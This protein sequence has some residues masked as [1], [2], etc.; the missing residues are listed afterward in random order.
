MLDQAAAT[1]DLPGI[2]EPPIDSQLFR[3]VFAAANVGK[4][5]T[6]ADGRVFP[7]QTFADMLGYSCEELRG[8]DWRSLTPPEDLPAIEAD[9]QRL[10]RDET[11][12]LRLLK[13]YVRKDRTIMWGDVSSVARRDPD[14]RL[15]YFITTIID[16]TDR[17]ATEARLRRSQERFTQAFQLGPAGMSIT[18]IS[19]GT[20]L[21]VNQEF[22]RTFGF[23]RAEVIGRTSVE[24]QLYSPEARAQLIRNQLA[25]GG[26]RCTLLQ[27]RAKTGESRTIRFSSQPVTIEDEP[28]HVTMFVDETEL[29]EIRDRERQAVQGGDVGLWSWDLRTQRVYYSPEWKKQIGYEASELTDSFEEWQSRVH[30]EDLPDALAAAHAFAAGPESSFEQEFRLRHRDGSWRQILARSSLIRDANGAAIRM[31]GSHVDITERIKLQEQFLQAQKLESVGRL[32]GGVAHDFNNVLT[33]IF[34]TAEMAMEQLK[35]GDSLRADLLEIRAADRA[36]ALTRQ[37]LAFSRK[38]VLNRAHVN[39]SQV[40]RDMEFML[41]RL[42]GEDITLVVSADAALGAVMADRGQMEQV[43]LNLGINARDAM[44]R[45]GTLEISTTNVPA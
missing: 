4:S 1:M 8:M 44:P 37:L 32:A 24:L 14:G 42:I 43:I 5:I 33:V 7:N 35:E 23:T 28:C 3:D 31:V 17:V 13:R 20:L 45:G 19:D 21:D 34:S 15:L 12:T 22:L 26:L 36:A 9:R 25:S 29:E 38:Q 30:P 11:R 39:L 2:A 16:V 27:V 6:S 18:R 41:R 40:V 10:I